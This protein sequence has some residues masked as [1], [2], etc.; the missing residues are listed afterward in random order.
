[1][2]HLGSR[3]S[4]LADGQLGP[5]E[6]ERALA[7]VAGCPDCAAELAAARD[8][9]RA[10]ASAGDVTPAPDLTAR[11]L[12]L[13]A[14]AGTPPEPEPPSGIWG[15]RLRLVPPDRPRQT[16]GSPWSAFTLGGVAAVGPAPAP[17]E[18]GLP[19][20]SAMRRLALGSIAGFGVMA[21]TLFVL[22]EQPVVVPS[23]HPAQ[24]LSLLG[25]AS[26]AGSALVPRV[27]GTAIADAPVVGGT[28]PELD[29][30]GGAVPSDE[31]A[32]GWLRSHGWAGPADLPE[33]WH[34]TS[35]KLTGDRGTVLE[36]DLTGPVGDV[37]VR[38]QRGRLDVEALAGVPRAEVG[39]RTVY[40][41]STSPW[42]VVWQC[43]DSVV[44]VVAPVPH[45]QIGPLVAGFPLPGY[46][47][48]FPARLTRG[49]DT[50]TG[51]LLD[52]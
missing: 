24:A 12:Q 19:R 21:A 37:V 33:G 4:A 20:R 32:L 16:H 23:D 44:E 18:H 14:D 26:S 3:L 46:D 39:G 48:T 49:W 45:E 29:L 31:L 9:R 15:A 22:G 5:A 6:T 35:V 30:A 8:A 13:A 47:D 25:G 42:H 7:H 10:L 34:V 50:A 27:T 1:M 41:L 17:L 52:P 43:R 40:E 38:E 2:S 28:A 36:V 51:A 11:L